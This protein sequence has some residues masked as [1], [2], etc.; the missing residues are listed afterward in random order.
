[1]WRCNNEDGIHCGEKCREIGVSGRHEGREACEIGGGSSGSEKKWKF[2]DHIGVNGHK[3]D[4]GE[5][6]VKVVASM[7]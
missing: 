3:L 2:N 7:Q 1:M 4:I 6:F 5:T